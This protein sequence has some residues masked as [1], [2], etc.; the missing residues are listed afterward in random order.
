MIQRVN[1]KA[2][3]LFVLPTLV[4]KCCTRC[5]CGIYLLLDSQVWGLGRVVLQWNSN[6]WCYMLHY[7]GVLKLTYLADNSSH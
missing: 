2:I 6:S 3:M 5:T 1:W 7:K 4:C